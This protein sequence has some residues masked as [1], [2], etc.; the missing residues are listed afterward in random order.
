MSLAAG[1]FIG[2]PRFVATRIAMRGLPSAVAAILTCGALLHSAS[3]R[4]QE[5]QVPL[6][7]AGHLH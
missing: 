1:L 6:D 2:I 4:A 3:A 5:V 7:R